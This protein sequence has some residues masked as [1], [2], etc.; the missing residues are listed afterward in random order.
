MQLERSD[1]LAAFDGELREVDEHRGIIRM[2]CPDRLL[3]FRDRAP[4][5]PRSPGEITCFECFPAGCAMCDRERARIAHRSIVRYDEAKC[6]GSCSFS[7]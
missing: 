1:V 4:C 7:P 3:H 6:V 2:G 5:F